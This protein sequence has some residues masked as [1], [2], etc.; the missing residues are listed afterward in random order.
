MVSPQGEEEMI[1]F[2]RTYMGKGKQFRTPKRMWEDLWRRQRGS[3]NHVM[4]GR[5]F[6]KI[7]TRH[8]ASNRH[9]GSEWHRA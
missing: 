5:N 8:I 2:L 1:P 7:S 3:L 9:V 4:G 6:G